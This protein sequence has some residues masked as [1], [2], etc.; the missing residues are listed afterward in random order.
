M[1]GDWLELRAV[2]DL[3][4]ILRIEPVGVGW[5]MSRLLGGQTRILFWNRDRKT[6]DWRDQESRIY[7]AVILG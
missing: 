5:V 2:R 4:S 7:V 3:R 6:W 1:A